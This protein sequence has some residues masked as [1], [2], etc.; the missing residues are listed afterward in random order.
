MP[1]SLRRT[2][3][4]VVAAFALTLT[5]GAC[6][7]SATNDPTVIGGPYVPGK[8]GDPQQP[9]GP[10]ATSPGQLVHDFFDAA[11]GGGETAARQVTSFFTKN[12]RARWH[13][14]D[15]KNSSGIL[16]IHLL[17]VD[18]NK[19]DVQGGHPVTVT[20]TV[21]G[22]LNDQGRIV[23]APGAPQAMTFY[24]KR[25]E[26]RSNQLRI[27]DFE[28]LPDGLVLEDQALNNL[29]Y[30]QQPIYFWDSGNK[31][32]VPDLRY[33][34]LTI[35]PEQRANQ[36]VGWL[37]RGQS[38][39]LESVNSV[40]N[41]TTMVSGATI[42]DSTLVVKLSPQAGAGKGPVDA[43]RLML[44]YQIQAS[45][46]AVT[47]R[48]LELW[49]GNT[50]V[51]P[52]G[53]TDYQQYDLS[54]T[55]RSPPQKYDIVDGAVKPAPGVT[56]GQA[57][58]L[59]VLSDKN[60]NSH[61]LYAAI[62]RDEEHAALVRSNPNGGVGLAIVGSDG[63]SV[64]AQLPR[65]DQV[66]GR[67]RPAWIP[68]TNGLLIAWSGG[69]YFVRTDGRVSQLNT[70]ALGSVSAVAVAP[71]GRRVVLI[72]NGQV[73]V[74]ELMVSG[75]TVA[76]DGQPQ[77]IVVDPQLVPAGVGWESEE[78][79]YIVGTSGS[80]GALWLVTVD[81]AV[82][83]NNS[84]TLGGQIPTDVVSFPQ[85]AFSSVEEAMVQT[86]SSPYLVRNPTVSRDG[87]KNPF[88]IV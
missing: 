69:L 76:L 56:S 45:L 43:Q 78:R 80:A 87:T 61:V 73:Y 53:P 27:D 79:V 35:P 31:A 25:S 72:A 33:V 77:N 38:S 48:D 64:Q 50:Q 84:P 82:A 65:T 86:D 16:V 21:V 71:E 37:I 15:F 49:I 41:L 18:D 22:T 2:V 8:L 51:H 4:A 26:E 68:G 14:P 5:L 81:G 60:T 19:A 62:N 3:I 12:G 34:A 74:S 46:L 57:P 7:V 1:E 58:N 52:V 17:N 13:A 20:Y 55:L 32:L 36:I 54:S 39:L 23:L 42:R 63:T 40:P 47:G 67:P 70:A 6:G 28:G 30:R 24:V 29:Y 85:G 59:A 83:I 10:T 44:Y 88:Y 66:T 75:N 9:A 11:A